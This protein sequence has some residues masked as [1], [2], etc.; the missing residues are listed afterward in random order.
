MHEEIQAYLS[1][2]QAAGFWARLVF[3]AWKFVACLCLVDWVLH[4]H[5]LF[6]YAHS[7]L[8]Q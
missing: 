8:T 4:A 3:Q 1:D 5:R 2:W 7:S 6:L